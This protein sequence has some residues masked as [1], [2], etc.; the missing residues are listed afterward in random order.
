MSDAKQ[1]LMDQVRQQAALQNARQLVE[2]LHHPSS[3]HSPLDLPSP[4]LPAYQLTS[5][6]QKLNEHCFERCVPS[7]GSSLSSSEQTCLT[8][9]MEK[10]MASW[11]AVS[12][13]Y[14]GHVQKGVAGQG[15]GL[16]GGL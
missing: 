9:C 4:S 12:R 3:S 15:G 1:Q 14:M 7:P 10:Y 8:H 13:Q 5:P 11:N 16:G 6:P 2:V